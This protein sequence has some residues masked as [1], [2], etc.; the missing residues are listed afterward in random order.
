MKKAL[1]IVGPT[2]V[3]KTALALKISQKI[4]SALISADSVQIYKGLDIISGK[5]LPKNAKFVTDHYEANSLCMYLLDE[6]SPFK[7]FSV[8]DFAKRAKKIL[9]KFYED[10][11]VP[12]IVGGAGFYVNSLIKGIETLKIPPDTKLRQK[13]SNFSVERLQKELKKINSS[14]F[15]TMNISD[16]NNPRRLARAI[17]VSLFEGRTRASQPYFKQNEVLMIGL[18]A[19]MNTIR[20]RVRERV[21]KRIEQGA[22]EEAKRLFADYGKL[23]DQVKSLSGYK[24]LF[25]YLLGKISFEEAKERWVMSEIHL[26]KRQITWFKKNANIIWFDINKRGFQKEVLKLI[27]QELG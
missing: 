2:A 12:V 13:L 8:Y 23:S 19:D 18:T 7:P 14:K 9:D 10:K 22:G 21:E 4:P 25:D 27:V 6:V 24:Q 20:E 17:E 1:F 15:E 5:D 26:A 16:I 11:K 3:G